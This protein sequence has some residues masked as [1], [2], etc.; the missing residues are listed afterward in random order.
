MVQMSLKS[1]GHNAYADD[2]Q[3]WPQGQYPFETNHEM[4]DGDMI[5]NVAARLIKRFVLPTFSGIL[6]EPTVATLI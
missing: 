3:A 5:C 2:G 4:T 6:V 1:L